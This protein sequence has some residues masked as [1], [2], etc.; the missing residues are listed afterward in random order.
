MILKTIGIVFGIGFIVGM[1][2]LAFIYANYILSEK[3]EN[4]DDSSTIR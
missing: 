1:M 3:K 2:V 4:K